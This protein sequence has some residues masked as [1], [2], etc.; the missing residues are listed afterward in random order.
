MLLS[1]TGVGIS[2]VLT[3]ERTCYEQ[4]T[5]TSEAVVACSSIDGG[6]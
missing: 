1:Y 2:E 3:V 5:T 4:G 6:E